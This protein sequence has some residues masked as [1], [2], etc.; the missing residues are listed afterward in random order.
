V[1]KAFNTIFATDFTHPTREGE[2][3]KTFIA[4]DDREAIETVSEIAT[5]MGFKPVLC[6]SLSASRNLEQM[7]LQLIE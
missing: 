2:Q 3:I 7:M 4:G 5:A 1:V 6:G